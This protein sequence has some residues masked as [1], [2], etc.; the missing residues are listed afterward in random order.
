MAILLALLAAVVA[1]GLAAFVVARLTTTQLSQRAADEREAAVAAAVEAV[2]AQAGLAFV[3]EREHTLRAA[4][5]SATS[6][7]TSKLQDSMTA[8]SR[9]LDLRSRSF[10]QQ[11]TH[12]ADALGTLGGLVQSLQKER[13]EQTGS[14]V[15]QLEHVTRTQQSLAEHTDQL[16]QALASPKQRGQWGERMAEDVLRAAGFRE[17]VS[18]RRQ[19]AIDGG[20]IP[21]FRFLLPRDL[22]LRMDVK[23]PVDNYLRVL[24]CDTDADRTRHTKAFVADVRNHV[25]GLAGRGYID[26][27]D[28]VDCLLLFIPNE[29]VYAFLHESD[30]DI[31]DVAL[32]QQVVLCSPST[33]FAVLAV[34]RRSVEQFQLERRSDEILRCLGGLSAEWDKLV[35]AIDKVGRQLDTAH[36]SFHDDLNGTRRRVFQRALDEIESLQEPESRPTLTSGEALAAQKAA[37]DVRALPVDEG[38][39]VA[40]AG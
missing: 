24:E 5:E 31:V 3:A 14:L 4:V 21:D 29:A 32:G 17:G 25:R 37:G 12:I 22:E 7:A 26:H 11:V 16:R 20:T 13:A 30:P 15:A 27:R 36:R 2:V 1:A 40:E 9:E 35:G 38:G 18:Y 34:V 28:T 23:F 19:T 6:V 10:E 33:L 8:G 39:D